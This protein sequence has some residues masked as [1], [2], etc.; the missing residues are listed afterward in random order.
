MELAAALLDA[1]AQ[2][3]EA[4]RAVGALPQQITERVA[5]GTAVEDAVSELIDRPGRIDGLGERV[6]AA[7][8]GAVAVAGHCSPVT[9]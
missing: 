8:E 3:V 5:H 9:A 6:R 2:V 1:A 4:A 7:V